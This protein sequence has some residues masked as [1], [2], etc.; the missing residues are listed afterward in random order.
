MN[1]KAEQ[2]QVYERRESIAVVSAGS[3]CRGYGRRPRLL[4]GRQRERESGEVIIVRNT[5]KNILTFMF[6]I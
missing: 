5:L 4:I 3:G 6:F 1:L 2:T